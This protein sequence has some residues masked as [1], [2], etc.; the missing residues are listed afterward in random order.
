MIPAETAPEPILP[1]ARPS[2]TPQARPWRPLSRAFA[3]LYGRRRR[4]L[5]R[6]RWQPVPEAHQGL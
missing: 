1:V 4:V 5:C 6:L 2:G 3:R